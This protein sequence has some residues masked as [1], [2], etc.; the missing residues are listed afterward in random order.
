MG[1]AA[2]IAAAFVGAGALVA[3]K[4]LPAREAERP[5]EIDA[6]VELRAAAA[7]K[8]VEPIGSAGV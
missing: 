2:L 5:E 1:T 8:A 6:A 3:A 4:W 7:A